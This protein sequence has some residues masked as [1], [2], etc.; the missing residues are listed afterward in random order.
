MHSST[1]NVFIK[2]IAISSCVC[3]LISSLVIF[4]VLSYKL[5]GN[6]DIP[7]AV[8]TSA[9][10]IENSAYST[11][12]IT[13]PDNEMRGV[14]I[15]SVTNIDFPSEKGLSADK[16]KAELDDIVKTVCES[17]LNAIF[18]Q[19]R[20]CGDAL[21]KS[22]IFPTSVYLT[23]VE[24]GYLPS[25]FDPLQYLIEIAHENGIKI[26]AWINPYRITFGTASK[27]N[28]DVNKLSD[29]NPAKLHPEWTVA[30]ADGKLYYNPGVPQV[31]DLIVSGVEEIIRNYSVD[32]I[33][34]DD[35][36]YPYPVDGASFDDSVEYALYGNGMNLE[37]WRREN[38]NSMIKACYTAIKRINDFCLFGVAPFGIWQNDD[39][40]NGGSD[41]RGFEAYHELYCDAL[42]WA[43]GGYVDY[44]A[45]QLYWEFTT[46]A[47]R[48]DQLSRWWNAELSQYDGVDLIIS[49]GAYKS[50]DYA[51]NEIQNQVQFSRSQRCYRGSI[52]FGYSSIKNNEGNVKNQLINVF[53]EQIIYTDIASDNS[54]VYIESPVN[55]TTLSSD[56]TYLI[57]KCDPKYPLYFEG[58]PVSYTKSGYFSIYVGLKNGSNTF[59]LTQNGL[60]YSHKVN[61]STA[62]GDSY[63]SMSSFVISSTSPCEN[64]MYRAGDTINL[65]VTA[66]AGSKVTATFE[67]KEYVLS[68]T[69]NPPKNS[70][71]MK[72]IY[73]GSIKLNSNYQ[74]NTITDCG[75]ID[76][77]AV[78][79][80][81]STVK[82]S[83]NIQVAGANAYAYVEVINDDSEMKTAVNSWYYDDY[84][85]T[86]VGMR[87][88]A[89]RLTD[90][91][92]Q[93]RMGAFVSADNVKLINDTV[94][95]SK[96]G[97]ARFEISSKSTQ[98]II[99]STQNVPANGHISNG[100]FYLTLYNVDGSSASFDGLSKD[101]P[102]FSSVSISYNEKEHSISYALQLRA[103][104]NYYGFDYKYS[105]NAVVF[106]FRNPELI[107]MLGKALEGKTIIL[108]A[109]HGGNDIGASGPD[110]IIHEADLNY[111]IACA[112]KE[113]LEDLG[114]TV[115]LTRGEDETLA[116]MDRVSLISMIEPDICISIH[117]NSADYSADIRKIHGLVGL[118]YAYS[119]N[120]LC[121]EI[122]DA[123][124]F[125]TSRIK[126]NVTTQR[127]AMTR[128]EEF[129]SCLIEV[130]F[131]T[132]PEEVEQL[133]G[134][135]GIERAACGIADGVMNYYMSQAKY[136]YTSVSG[137]AQSFDYNQNFANINS[138][139]I[140]SLF[141]LIV[142]K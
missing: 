49:H 98:F 112:A 51:E 124:S 109:G 21:Y 84:T 132:S 53:K 11:M 116:L 93:L 65:S 88:C 86:T 117:Q 12:N 111:S 45:P 77:K 9:L 3:F 95:L 24:G 74:D 118:Y 26:H 34:F 126:R 47:A 64:S 69:I 119:G 40:K 91:F 48:Y 122:S 102:L 17:N 52:M 56:N 108:D 63:A 136:C 105:K 41:S 89:L 81:N 23:G 8:Y 114:A 127:L 97:K 37:D 4:A 100:I 104:E 30:Y 32:G 58:K 44:L 123:V 139:F 138:N 106:T 14:Y 42:A 54:G 78:L 134:G 27:P 22:D 10:P 1:K 25:G 94:P 46:S 135:N 115:L 18:F 15:A 71:Y 72:E 60:D 36:F 83:G 20:P 133:I 50:A 19:V 110:M 61:K 16:L 70:T 28:N 140:K 57:G 82:S 121:S 101:N 66:P 103:L 99:T 39:G 2:V 125:N 131:M 92:Y 129:P 76:F 87:D 130:G 96:I 33:I 59:V 68:P 62:S 5:S 142:L 29:N 43:K 120:M 128:N 113:K 75:S 6:K 79:G 80:G 55:G 137:R 85:P 73:V 38:I 107:S 13:N 7:S 31:T 90:G 141:N 67:N 35:Y